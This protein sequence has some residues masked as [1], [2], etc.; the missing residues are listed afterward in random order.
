VVIDTVIDTVTVA[1]TAIDID[2]DID[3]LSAPETCFQ[4]CRDRDVT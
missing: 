3:S 2:I 4:P 1:V